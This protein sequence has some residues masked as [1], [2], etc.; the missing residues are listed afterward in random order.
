MK[1]VSKFLYTLLSGSVMLKGKLFRRAAKASVKVVGKAAWWSVKSVSK[2]IFYGTVWLALRT[3]KKR[4]DLK[5]EIRKVK[6]V[7]TAFVLKERVSGNLDQLSQKLMSESLIIAVCGRRG[8][9]KSALGFRLLENIHALARRPC[10]ALDIRQEVLPDWITEVSDINDVKNS[11][12]LLI[13]EGAV[14]FSARKSMTKKNKEL[15]DL[16]AIARHKDLTL[17]L[18]TQNTGMLDKNVLN[19][20]DVLFLKEGS[21]LQKEMERPLMKKLYA[22]AAQRFKSLTRL[23]KKSHAYVIDTDFEGLIAA[24]LPS[25]WSTKISKNQA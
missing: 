25:F 1:R 14:S 3:W 12:V 9:G 5:N 13:D 2:G 17:I 6:A 21:L 16:L 19:L 10:F 18:V 24:E 22:K 15:G 4:K 11:G 20:C 23:E 8:C 7:S